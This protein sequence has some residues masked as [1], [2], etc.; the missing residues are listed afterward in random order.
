MKRKIFSILFALVLV[1]SFSLVAA[2]PVAAATIDVTNA[3]NT[4]DINT[5]IADATDGDVVQFADGEYNLTEP[6]VVGVVGVT[7]TGDITTPDNVV[8]NAPTGIT[9]MDCFQVKV[10]DV[11]I[12]GFKIQG[13]QDG[14]SGDGYQNAGVAIGAYW[15]AA[16]YS[17]RGLENIDISYNEF[18]DCSK[19]IFMYHVKD[20]TVSYN[21][22]TTTEGQGPDNFLDKVAWN[23]DGVHVFL[24]T[25]EDYPTGNNISFNTME[26]VRVGI[27]LNGGEDFPGEPPDAWDFSGTTIEGNTMTAVWNAGIILQRASGTAASPIIIKDNNIDTSIGGRIGDEDN[28]HGLI[29]VHGD[30][31]EITGNTLTNSDEHGL[32]VDGS[33][34]MVEGNIV[35]SNT[36]DGIH[37]GWYKQFES[38]W[39][40]LLEITRADITI[41]FNNIVGNTEYGVQNTD[42]GFTLDATNNWWGGTAGPDINTNP[43]Y[44][45]AGASGQKNDSVSTYVDYIPWLIHTDLVSGWNIYST[46]IACGTSTDTIPEALDLWTADASKVTAVYY[47]N[48]SSQ[49]FEIATT[50]LTLTPL[51]P[52]YLE[53]SAAATIDVISSTSNTAPPSQ[54]AYA[55]WNLIGLAQ[56]YSMPAED[57]LA[58]AYYVAGADNIGYSQVVSPG[59]GQAAWNATR[60]AAIDTLSGKT[61]AP[62]EGYWMYMVNQGI[63]AGFTS[64]PI[65][66]LP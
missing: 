17:I 64:T 62:C 14:A 58:S 15:A 43:Y 30:Y 5:A 44:A 56:L 19:G 8:V 47:F 24:E 46:P 51:V 13:A 25:E 38:V 27:I 3:M 60:K 53:M 42:D 33:H 52:V 18:V 49:A 22:F 45:E 61:M 59:L 4:A 54:T 66:E 16:P 65:T 7:L 11:T 31:T 40:S 55:G 41:N 23:G 57:A 36:K 63:L 21:T 48:G 28:E 26:N 2:V 29:S 20:T 10:S 35:T 6:L 9:D 34:H 12:Q 1:M 50:S 39:G 37:V 32:W